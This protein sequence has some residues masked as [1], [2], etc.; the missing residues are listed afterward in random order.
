VTDSH[1]GF[2]NGLRR[3]DFRVF[4]NGVERPITAF[5]SNE[6][7]AQVVLLIECGTADHLLAKLGSSLFVDA[8]MFLSRIPSNDRIAVVTYSNR[9]YVVLGFTSDKLAVQGALKDLNS[10]LLHA[11]VGSDSLNLSS[12]LAAVLYWL[13][14]VPGKKAIVLL[15]IGIDTSSPENWQLIQQELK[16]SDVPLLAVSALGDFR[17]F[18][19]RQKLSA[20]VRDEQAYVKRGMSEADQW[21]HQLSLATGGHAYFPKNSNDF[22]SAYTEIAEFVRGEY[23]L[24]FVPSLLDGKLHAITVKVKQPWY[25]SYHVDHREAYVAGAPAAK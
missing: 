5:A 18:P 16:A 15:S 13:R 14:T 11:R 22:D 24:G 20:D 19:E 4:D 9:S 7:P 23:T 25:R 1:G 6:D 21:L 8:D 12:S 2:I 3:D 17:K 10:Q